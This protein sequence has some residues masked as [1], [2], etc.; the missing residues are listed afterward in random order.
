MIAW[1]PP[2]GHFQKFGCP[3]GWYPVAGEQGRRDERACDQSL[4]RSNEPVNQ[5]E[6]QQPQQ[7]SF[8]HLRLILGR[9]SEFCRLTQA[10]HGGT[11]GGLAKAS[12]SSR[13]SH[14]GK[15]R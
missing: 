12:V 15:I 9:A 13:S 2:V 11:G 14:D 10:A 4:S 5:G 1:F 3:P 8:W 6:G 7:F